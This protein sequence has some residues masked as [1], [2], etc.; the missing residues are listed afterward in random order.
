MPAMF[1][2]IFVS[3]GAPTLY[4]DSGPTHDFLR[5]LGARL[6]RPRAVLCVSAHWTT[7]APA[8]TAMERPETIH[9]FY[10]FPEE[11][12]AV[13]YPAPGDPALAARSAELLGAA[14]V[15]ASLDQDWGLD[16]GAWV[17]LGL[18]YPEA[19][20]PVVQLAVQPGLSPEL[21]LALGRALRPL[22]EEGVLVLGSGGA[23][24]NL[25][26][27]VWDLDV[28][29]PAYIRAFDAWLE[30]AVLAGREEDLC[31]YAEQGPSGRRAHPTPEHFLP[32]FVPLG[33]GGRARVLH[34]AFHYGTLSMKA[35]AW[36]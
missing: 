33:T 34:R 17:P 9:D 8:L 13:R 24:H 22:R 23:T 32:L 10:G 14:G 35:F 6:G 20:V 4:L 31:A 26:E 30:E 19:D 18:M 16:H 11:L 25:R 36:D 28:E 2:A 1:P 27:M 12:E 3:H 21:H 15:A 7:A 5:D 29:P